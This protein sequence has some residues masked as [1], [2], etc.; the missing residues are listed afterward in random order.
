MGNSNSRSN[1]NS[2][3]HDDTRSNDGV[4]ITHNTTNG[5][6]CTSHHHVEEDDRTPNQT[7]NNNVL[8]NTTTTTTSRARD[9]NDDD[10]SDH[11]NKN[12]DDCQFPCFLFFTPRHLPFL[13][14]KRNDPHTFH[15]HHNDGSHH[16]NNNNSHGGKHNHKRKDPVLG[17]PVPDTPVMER[18]RRQ[19]ITQ[20][21]STVLQREQQQQ[22]QQQKSS[23]YHGLEK[24]ESSRSF[25]LSNLIPPPNNNGGS[26]S[27]S[28][29]MTMMNQGNFLTPPNDDNH[30]AT[31]GL[32][33]LHHHPPPVPNQPLP[34]VPS[35]QPPQQQYPEAE[36][37]EGDDCE[38]RLYEK[39]ELC[40]VLGVGSTST[41]HR[42]VHK[43]TGN[44]YACKIIDIQNMDV[45]YHSM[46]IQFHT[47][48]TSLKSIHHPGIIQLYDVYILSTI[49]IYI[50]MELMLGGE[51]F[52]YVVEKG[53]LSEEEASQIVRT[54]LS[55][56]HYLHRQNIIHRDL[57][58]ENLLL[59]YKPNTTSTSTT[60]HT[61]TNN[62]NKKAQQ[63][64]PI[65]VKII[66]FGL[67]KLMTTDDTVA[68]TF[69]GTRG[70]LAPEML[71]RREYTSAVDTWAMGVIV[72]VLLCGCLPFDD[73]A[74]MI[75]PNDD[76][77]LQ[78]RF[79]L[80]FPRWAKTLSASAKDLL[81][82]LLDI[83]PLTRYTAEQALYHPWVRGETAPSKNLLAS[84]GRI[85]KSPALHTTTNQHHHHNNKNPAPPSWNGNI[86]T[87]NYLGR[88]YAPD[89]CSLTPPTPRVRK[90]SF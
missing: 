23:I 73:D 76:M 16:N 7:G 70:Y 68:S 4:V 29:A 52:D 12:N 44:E 10:D 71:Q 66:D 8:R 57:K 15:H 90:G 74:T 79:V 53:T 67:S 18:R 25:R 19:E 84:P 86:H 75:L 89:P 26:S 69:L 28:N 78:K 42:C 24:E 3:H 5:S 20:K 40:E 22:Q 17:S 80:R 36:I 37:Y 63:S 81:N 85:R 88:K 38:E 82:H 33:L 1:S 54:V 31:H 47:E 11:N 87:K 14:S 21:A 48:I 2:H 72:F 6:S 61:T 43:V 13:Q 59:K 83:N 46:M 51:L 60:S 50:I 34:P 39:Y 27:A 77:V 9:N 45:Q 32:L 55:A 49:K 41:V 64:V 65:D 30:A 62:N 56:I 35:Q 58:P